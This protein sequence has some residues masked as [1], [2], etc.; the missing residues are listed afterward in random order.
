MCSGIYAGFYSY[1]IATVYK[2]ELST[3]T[4]RQL[5]LSLILY[6]FHAKRGDKPFIRRYKRRVIRTVRYK[7]RL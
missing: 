1:T 5:L 4:A 2:K 7:S 3:F 6:L